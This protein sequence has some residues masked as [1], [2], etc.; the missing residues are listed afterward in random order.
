M[1][2]LIVYILPLLWAFQPVKLSAIE[3]VSE[4]AFIMWTPENANLV[5][6]SPT[7]ET[8]KDV[9]PEERKV[10]QPVQSYNTPVLNDNKP[11][12]SDNNVVRKLRFV[13]GADIAANVDMSSHDASALG[14][15]AG[16]GFQYKAIRFL[17]VGAAA[18]V[19]SSSSS[20]V[21]PL[22]LQFRT[23]FSSRSRL[24]FLDLRGGMALAYFNDQKRDEVPYVSGGIG[25][26]L[27]HGK[28][29][30][31]HLVTSYSWLGQRECYYGETLRK[32]PGIS[33]VTIRLGVAF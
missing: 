13:W 6:T 30:S 26:T 33:Y 24:L 14:I 3:T 18:N 2:K 19:M 32:C 27:A 15:E 16:F 10:K 21:Y 5:A 23:D 4:G 22:T 20:R 31:S 1:K 25:V 9:E 11:K 8:K 28:T 7:T 17:G 29:F 12:Q